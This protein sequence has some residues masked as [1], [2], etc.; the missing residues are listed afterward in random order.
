[1]YAAWVMKQVSPRRRGAAFG[2]ILAAFDTGIGTGS[3]AIGWIAQHHGF[4]AAFGSAAALS[5][6]SIP[7][8]LWVTRRYPIGRPAA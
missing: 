4:R 8:F 1:V 2:G 5:L 7:Y 6:L 3:I